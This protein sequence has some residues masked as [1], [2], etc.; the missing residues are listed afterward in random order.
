[1]SRVTPH[2]DVI[3]ALQEFKGFT[4][5]SEL[6]RAMLER[7]F[8]L[9]NATA[10]QR[11]KRA[12]QAGA[13]VEVEGYR[14]RSNSRIV[15]LPE[16]LPQARSYVRV[17]L[18]GRALLQRKATREKEER[19]KH[20]RGQGILFRASPLVTI[21]YETLPNRKRSA[22]IN[23]ILEKYVQKHHKEIKV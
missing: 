4:L 14:G 8:N 6:A 5:S 9:S 17:V 16:A 21:W 12:K 10:R 19:T 11:I 3:L 1:M 13:I 18:K 20:A 7:D 2:I 23:D 15:A 22:M